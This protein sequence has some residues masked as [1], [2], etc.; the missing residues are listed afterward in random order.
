MIN[1]MKKLLTVEQILLIITTGKVC[2][3]VWTICKLKG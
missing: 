3:T 2:R 1:E